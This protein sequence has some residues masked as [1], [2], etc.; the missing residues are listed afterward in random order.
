VLAYSVTGTAGERR[1]YEELLTQFDQQFTDLKDVVGRDSKADVARSDDLMARIEQDRARFAAASE[2]LLNARVATA[3]GVESLRQMAEEMVLELTVLRNRYQPNS[4]S[5]DFTSASGQPVSLALRNQISQLLFGMEGMMSIVAWESAISSGYAITANPQL[6]DRFEFAA[7]QWQNFLQTA[8]ANAGTDDQAILQRVET[9]FANNF[10]PTAR[11][12]IA[13]T[14]ESIR[15]RASFTEASASIS[16]NF[17]EL[18]TVQTDRLDLAQ[19]DAKSVSSTTRNLMLVLTLAAF[20]AA[21]AAGLWFSEKITRPIRQLRDVANQVST[22]QLNDVPIAADP[23]D[24]VGE[25]AGAFRRMLV[26]IRILMAHEEPT[27]EAAGKTPE[28]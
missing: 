18:I 1:R 22:G 23:K 9:K 7:A 6:L 11:K 2:Q 3:D 24:E 16:R 25:L 4:S 5:G 13:T 20:A 10:E 15:T 12:L 28:P 21:G 14:D 8:K 27:Y 26:S 17:D 19:H